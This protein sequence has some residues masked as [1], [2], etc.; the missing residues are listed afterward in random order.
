MIA[1]TVLNALLPVVLT[2]LLGYLA[3]W[4]HDADTNVAAVLNRIVLTYAL[5]LALFTGT[6]ANTRAQLLSDLPLAITLLIGLVVPYVAVVL[7]AHFLVKRDWAE[8]AMWGLV[9]GSPAT[10][11]TGLPVLT[12]VVGTSATVAVAMA[13]V[14]SNL[15]VIPTAI[16]LI[17]L[18]QASTETNKATQTSFAQVLKQSV[19]Q[20][21]VLAPLFGIVLVML[22][23]GVPG[24][25]THAAGLMGVSSAGL[26][27]FASG[28]ILQAQKPKLTV[29][30][31]VL[32][33]VRTAVIPATVLF[34]LW[35]LGQPRAIQQQAVLALGLPAGTMQVIFAV[36]YHVNEQENASLLLFTNVASLITLAIFIAL[37]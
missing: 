7:I 5:P 25:L 23:V 24:A 30:V 16:V 15:I 36:K 18:Q 10:S 33:L 3:G 28:I 21:V 13:G 22:G 4:H 29:A 9:M 17:N 31:S 34:C 12:A 11:F 2:L 27:L 35:R 37:L 1:S 14:I 32:A 26:S 19:M 8:S 6:V 20:P